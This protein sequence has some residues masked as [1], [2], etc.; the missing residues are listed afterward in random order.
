[1]KTSAISILLVIT[2]QT[3]A[4]A[5]FFYSSK[6][7]TTYLISYGL[8][9][10]KQMYFVMNCK[11]YRNAK[12]IMAFPDGGT[13]KIVSDVIG[14]YK[15][16]LDYN[17]L[18]LLFEISDEKKNRTGITGTKMILEGDEL[19][20]SYRCSSDQYSQCMFKYNIK[21]NTKNIVLKKEGEELEETIFKDYWDLYRDERTPISKVKKMLKIDNA[22]YRTLPC[23][24]VDT[25]H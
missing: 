1:M 14:V 12:G 20:L 6:V 23:P 13:P 10:E 22:T 16:N 7:L 2:F 3:S 25:D 24:V 15:M 21:T 11:R 5:G 8:K 9:A 4:F 19:Y 18:N 17:N